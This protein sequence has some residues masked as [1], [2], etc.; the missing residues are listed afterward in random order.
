MRVRPLWQC[1]KCGRH[2]ANRNQSHACG[3][4]D[5]AHHFSGK[6]SAIRAVFDAVVAALR[7]IGPVRIIPEKTRIAFQVRMSFAQVTPKLKWLDGHIVLARR[8]THRRFRAVQTISPRNHV[9]VFRLTSPR[10]VDAQFRAWLAEA[11]SV[12]E[13]KHLGKSPEKA[14]LTPPEVTSEEEG[15][16][17]DLVF[18]IQEHKRLPDGSQSIRGAGTHKGR[19]LGLD[20]V[21]G[22]TWQS[23]SLGKDIP[24]VTYRGIVT[25]R[26][27]GADS[28]AFVQVLDELYG[29]K[30]SP[31]G[32][33]REIQFT[34]IS[35]E[36]DP[37]DLAKGP[38]KIKLLF[39][40]GVQDDYAE[41]FTNIELAA[42][43][44]EVHEKD[45]EYR[46]P[47]VRALRTH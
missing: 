2:F 38:V 11:Y 42:R 31:K 32:M 24:L 7:D 37:R 30:L 28:D 40:S 6:S 3:R 22:P 39:E 35:L 19:P 44:L 36:G 17:H 23:G 41:L 8:I 20:V 12:G 29:T 46:S 16:F 13:Q 33:G 34:G 45:E 27:T 25:Y 4:H 15:G 26:S 47:V 9:H 5:L 18:Y 10:E 43:R 21:L 14:G 1:Q